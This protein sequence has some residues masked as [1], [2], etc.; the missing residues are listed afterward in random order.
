MAA[1]AVAAA[2]EVAAVAAVVAAVAVVEVA[3]AAVSATGAVLVPAASSGGAVLRVEGMRRAL[4]PQV[5]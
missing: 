4:R 2:A 3:A 5:A 1:E